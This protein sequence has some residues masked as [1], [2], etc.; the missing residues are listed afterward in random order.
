MPLF[1]TEH[2]VGGTG[3]TTVIHTVTDSITVTQTNYSTIYTSTETII[4]TTATVTQHITDT[5]TSTVSVTVTETVPVTNYTIS[6]STYSGLAINTSDITGTNTI[7]S[8][9]TDTITLTSES[10]DTNDSPVV[11]SL[12]IAFSVNAGDTTLAVVDTNQT[13][14]VQI[15]AG[16]AVFHILDDNNPGGEDA[17]IAEMSWDGNNFYFT[18]NSPLENAYDMN[19]TI[20]NGGWALT[21]SSFYS[22]STTITQTDTSSH[23]ETGIQSV[24]VNYTTYQVT[25]TYSN[26]SVLLPS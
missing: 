9:I 14:S 5:V 8:T 18:L 12:P 10:E 19:A 24:T 4:N 21:E 16:A 3:W 13:D 15:S 23:T 20:S 22:Y 26:E 6:S 7:L 1:Y 17:Y 11:N 2:D 25:Y